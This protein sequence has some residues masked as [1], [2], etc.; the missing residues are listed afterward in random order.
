NFP[1]VAVR[2]LVVQSRTGDLVVGTHGRGIW[3]IDDLAP[4]RA[5]SDEVLGKSVAFLPSRVVQQRM[6]GIGGWATGDAKFTGENPLP[7]AVLSYNQK[8]RHL[9]GPLKLEVVGPDKKVLDTVPTGKR[10]GINRVSWTMRV[11]PPR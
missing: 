5:L 9:F 6:P 3:I 1:A 4:L 2:D 7:G 8:T 10:R 11:A